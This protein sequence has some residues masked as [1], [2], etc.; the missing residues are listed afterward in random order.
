MDIRPRKGDAKLDKSP[1]D[2]REEKSMNK[3]FKSVK[4]GVKPV[5]KDT[6]NTRRKETRERLVG[7]T[8]KKVKPTS[9]LK[10]VMKKPIITSLRSGKS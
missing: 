4:R 7:E 2:R 6:N 3:A 10:K 9:N 5:A 8:V 1:Y